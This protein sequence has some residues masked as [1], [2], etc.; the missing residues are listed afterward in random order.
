MDEGR[1]ALPILQSHI[2]S[3]RLKIQTHIHPDKMIMVIH[4]DNE[5]FFKSQAIGKPALESRTEHY[6]LKGLLPM[7]LLRLN[8]CVAGAFK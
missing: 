4:I 5:L 6:I 3:G 2:Q 1:K 8:N 7:I